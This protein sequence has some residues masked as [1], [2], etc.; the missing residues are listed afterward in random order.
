MRISD[1]NL[2]FIFL[3][4]SMLDIILIENILE[5]RIV[6]LHEETHV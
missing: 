1:G 5:D 4:T 2:V 3:I 6:Y